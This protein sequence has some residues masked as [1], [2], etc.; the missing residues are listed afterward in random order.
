MKPNKTAIGI[1][2]ALFSFCLLARVSAAEKPVLLK[3]G[4]IITVSGGT[5]DGGDIL[6]QGTKIARVGQGLAAPAGAET[7]DLAGRWVMPGI[8]DSHSHI[9][10]EGGVNEMGNLITAEVDCRDIINPQDINIF[11]ALTGGVT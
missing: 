9:A 11:Y 6:I 7:I 3:N 1:A 5:I 10:I 8:I 2:A 4:R